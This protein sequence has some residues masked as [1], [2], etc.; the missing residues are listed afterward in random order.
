MATALV[1][2]GLHR[3]LT[4]EEA[5]G[6]LNKDYR[7]RVPRRKALEVASTA[8]IQQLRD[9]L[10]GVST[11][12]KQLSEDQGAVQAVRLATGDVQGA[13]LADDTAAVRAA[14]P[15]PPAADPA[16]RGSRAFRTGGAGS[17]TS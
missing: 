10:E 3:H 11:W 15:P 8:R 14:A 6:E 2:T 9:G 5:I 16:M 1:A 12:I 13:S 17:V 7:L 4:Y